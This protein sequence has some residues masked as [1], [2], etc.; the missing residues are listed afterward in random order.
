MC[1]FV[2]H[3]SE[4]RTP[5]GWPAPVDFCFSVMTIELVWRTESL[6]F[7]RWWPWMHQT[8]S[9]VLLCSSY[10]RP[11]II[12]LFKM[13]MS[14]LLNSWQGLGPP[15]RQRS[16]VLIANKLEWR[17]RRNPS[18]L[19]DCLC[20]SF[21]NTVPQKWFPMAPPPFGHHKHIFQHKHRSRIH[22]NAGWHVP[23]YI[24]RTSNWSSLMLWQAKGRV[25]GG[26]QRWKT[27]FSFY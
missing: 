24:V 10:V 8:N 7:S 1:I 25:S 18:P 11:Y 20:V 26:V 19:S 17:V 9:P 15:N 2:D 13:L 12:R 21:T 6:F 4:L 27:A 5:D 3:G 23:S 14:V 22:S 16:I